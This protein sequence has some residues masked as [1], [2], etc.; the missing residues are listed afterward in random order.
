MTKHILILDDSLTVRMDLHEAL[1]EAGFRTTL[2]ATVA[3]AREALAAGLPDLLVLDVLLPDGNGIA[4]LR[5]LK[6]RPETAH[7]PVMLLSSE[8]EVRDRLRGMTTGADDYVGKPYDRATVATRARELLK[9]PAEPRKGPLILVIDDSRTFQHALRR[10]LEE[11]GYSVI[12]ALSGEEGLR[13]AASAR[14]DAAIVDG[15]LPGIDGATVLRR[16]RMDAALRRTPCLLLTAAERPEDELAALEAGADAY[17]RK[18]ETLEIVLARLSALLRGAGD[19]LPAGSDPSGLGPKRIL[20]VDDSTAYLHDLARHLRDEGYDVALAHSGEE[21]LEVLAVQTF[22]GILLDLLMPGMSGSEACRIIKQNPAWRDIPLAI[23]SVADSPEVMIDGL[24]SGADDFIVKGQDFDIVKGRLRAQL[25]RKHFEEENRRIREELLRKE[26]EATESRAARELAETRATLL[27]NL[28]RNNTELKQAKEQAEAATAAK[29]EFLSNMSHEIRTPLNAILG[30]ADLLAQTALTPE[31]SKY[32]GIFQ[33]AG[34]TLLELVNDILDL[35]KIEAGQYEVERIPYDLADL[36]ERTV[37]LYAARADEKHLTLQAE[38]APDVPTRLLGS[39]HPLGQILRNLLSNALKFTE[40]GSVSL[41]VATAPGNTLRLTVSDTGIGIAPEKRDLIFESFTQA[42][43]STTRKFGGTGLGLAISKQLIERLGG[44]LTLESKLGEGSDF[45]VDL[46]CEHDPDPTSREALT[47]RSQ[48]PEPEAL[49]ILV[50]E[51]SE[52]NRLVLGAYLSQTPHEVTMVENGELAVAR[53]KAEPFDLVLMDMQMPVMDGY[54]ATRAIRRWE[55]QRGRERTPIIALTAFA[56]KQET[57]RS[58]EAG[59]DMHLT[60]PFKRAQLLQAIADVAAMRDPAEDAFDEAIRQLIPGYL[61]KRAQD[62]VLLR[63]ALQRGAFDAI[64]DI[65][66][67]MAG[68]GTSYGFASL[69]EIGRGLETAAREGTSQEIA[70]LLDELE[71]V[72]AAAQA[73]SETDS[74]T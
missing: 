72:L 62:L 33:R 66:H 20:A 73:E 67:R 8:A 25:R 6:T 32:V 47:E 54:A 60:K 48:A 46:P 30:M 29:S 9:P 3:A 16:L 53:F 5:D 74:P 63:D 35:A 59:C 42:D 69:T 28:A 61:A 13:V 23:L 52:D 34:D 36:V 1:E 7:L 24:N 64:K 50:A 70:R 38:I 37:S 26:L 4:L 21:A 22:D 40:R 14:P 43:A 68:S 12:S 51:D 56:L 44:K 55:D 31:Q 58:L 15:T 41:R 10:V 18:S 19:P 65:G 57:A 71:A 11:A 2:C 39:P 27:A 17:L 49:R 45:H